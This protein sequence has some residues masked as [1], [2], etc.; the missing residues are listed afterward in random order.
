MFLPE[1]LY[2]YRNADRIASRHYNKV[3]FARSDSQAAW[4]LL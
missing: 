4:L 1:V 2:R 3:S